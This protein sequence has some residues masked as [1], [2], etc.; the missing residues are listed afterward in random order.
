MNTLTSKAAGITPKTIFDCFPQLEHISIRWDRMP[1]DAAILW[2]RSESGRMKYKGVVRLSGSG[3]Y[4]WISLW[5]SSL[6]PLT[7]GIRF[8]PW[9]KPHHSSGQAPE[10]DLETVWVKI[11]LALDAPISKGLPNG[12]ESMPGRVWQKESEFLRLLFR[13]RRRRRTGDD[14][15]C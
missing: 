12:R 6:D 5:I 10:S 11:S 13:P 15:R 2:P 8:T 7:G 4:Y 14:R 3:F 1:R 9:D